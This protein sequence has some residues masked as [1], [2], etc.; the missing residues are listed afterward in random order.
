MGN[1]VGGLFLPLTEGVGM[2]FEAR[3]CFARF[4]SGVASIKDTWE[5][6]LMLTVGF[7]FRTPIG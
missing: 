5:N 3:D 7:S 6:D 4:D 1:V 2:R